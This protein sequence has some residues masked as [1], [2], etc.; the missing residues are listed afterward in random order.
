MPAAAPTPATAAAGETRTEKMS[1]LRKVIAERM[2]ESLRVSAQL[3]SVVEADVTRIAAL[4]TKNKSSFEA[5]EGVKLS[6]MP[7]FAKAT[8]EALK[9]FPVINASIDQEAGTVTYH[10]AIHLGIAVDTE[11]GLLV[12]V[13]RDADNLNLAYVTQAGTGNIAS[14]DQGGQAQT[15]VVQQFGSANQA[16]VIQQ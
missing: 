9:Q 15:A 6:F 12:P 14:V 13:V 8:I 1:R 11:R 4:R 3:T 16:S 10:G 5:R 2:V 7:F